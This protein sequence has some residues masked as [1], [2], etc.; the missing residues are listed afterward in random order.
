MVLASFAASDVN[1]RLDERNQIENSGA[2]KER[3]A[4]VGSFSAE[5]AAAVPV[6]VAAVPLSGEQAY[7]SCAACHA[8]GIAGAPAVGDP[9]AWT[10]RIEQGLDTL[11]DHAING[12]QGSAGMM[13][14]KGG[15]IALSDESVKAAVDYMLE[16]SR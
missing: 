13:P 1:T 5:T 4:P 15:N 8:A 3:I 10:A 16:K 11:Y 7:A 9:D 6:V 2:I 12:Y 14:A